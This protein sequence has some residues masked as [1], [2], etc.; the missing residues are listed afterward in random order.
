MYVYVSAST[1]RAIPL[2]TTPLY[3]SSTATANDEAGKP[4]NTVL[5]RD[6]P[7]SV[8]SAPL[9]VAT[10]TTTAK[11]TDIDTDIDPDSLIVDEH[12]GEFESLSQAIYGCTSGSPSCDPMIVSACGT[13]KT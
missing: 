7:V 9:T 11:D 5:E 3:R 1:F 4:P 12:F 6:L 13:S 10:S 2:V 8:Y